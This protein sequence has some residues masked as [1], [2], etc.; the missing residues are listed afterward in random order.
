MWALRQRQQGSASYRLTL[1]ASVRGMRP[2]GQHVASLSPTLDV[3]GLGPVTGL[4]SQ[5]RC[6]PT[7][8]ACYG[9]ALR[10]QEPSLCYTPKQPPALGAHQQHPTGSSQ[11]TAPDA[12]RT[13]PL[14]PHVVATCPAQKSIPPCP[15]PPGP[16]PS[17]PSREPLTLFLLHPSLVDCVRLFPA[18]LHFQGSVVGKETRGQGC[19]L[20]CLNPGNPPRSHASADRA[21]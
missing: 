10:A 5:Q 8:G 17:Q 16:F 12:F 18:S 20:D 13:T 6:P 2:A 9:D 4:G 7:T 15:L 14:N 11:G 19:L 3:L 21:R 1:L